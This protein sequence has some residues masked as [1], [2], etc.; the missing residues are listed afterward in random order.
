M[1]K[2]ATLSTKQIDVLTRVL[3]HRLIHS[4]G[5]RIGVRS[6]KFNLLDRELHAL[7]R[8]KALIIV[9]FVAS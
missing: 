6:A 8:V 7:R 2:Y 3:G 1:S 9:V 4:S 5:I